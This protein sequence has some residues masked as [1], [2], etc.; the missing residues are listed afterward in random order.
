MAAGSFSERYG[1]NRIKDIQLD[2]MDS[3]LKNRIWNRFYDLLPLH[4]IGYGYDQP[5][6]LM[7]SV[8]RNFFKAD[9]DAF[10]VGQY[11]DHKRWI[12]DRF[13]RLEW[14]K[15]YDFLEFVARGLQEEARTEFID[16]CNTILEEENSGYRFIGGRIT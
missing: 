5:S 6:I 4:G 13:F 15:A 3:D 1:H 14:F 16:D 10:P 12:K 7:K 11:S 9:A 8:W 2:D